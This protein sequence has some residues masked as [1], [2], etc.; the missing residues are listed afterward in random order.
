MWCLVSGRAIDP[1]N[2]PVGTIWTIVDI[3]PRKAAEAEL[4]EA[5]AREK[6][7]N[8]LR[9]RFVSMT[10]HEFRTPLAAIMSSIELLADYSDQLPQQEKA[11]LAGVIKSSVRRMTGMLENILVIRQVGG[12]TP[13][14]P[15][16]RRR[17]ARTL[18]PRHRGRARRR[19]RGT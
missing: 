6:E 5:L 4:V 1:D 11:E 18:R 8:E 13:R 10:S 19:G 9:S 16:R 15:S 17:S 7:L 12:G 3:S 14:V 2:I